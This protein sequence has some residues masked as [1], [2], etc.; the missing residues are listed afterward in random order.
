MQD[1]Q[2]IYDAALKRL[3]SHIENLG[4]SFNAEVERLEKDLQDYYAELEKEAKQ[5]DEGG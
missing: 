2:D 3:A 1:I 4:L 5:D